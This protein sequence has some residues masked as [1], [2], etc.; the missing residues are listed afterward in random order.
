VCASRLRRFAKRSSAMPRQSRAAA[1]EDSMTPDYLIVGGGSAGC[2]LAERLSA[3]PSVRGML[4]E[5]GGSDRSPLIRA[6]GGLLPIMMSGAYAWRYMSAPQRHLDQRVLYT[7][8]GKV[9]G[10]GSSIN[11]MVYCRGTASDY[12]HWAA[13][14][15]RGW[16]Y[17]EVLPYFKRAENYYAGASVYHGNSGPI[18]VTRP[19]I[20]SPLAQAF[21]AAGQ[22]AG[23]AYND[24]TNAA[25]RDGFGPVDLTVGAGRRSSTASAY[26]RPALQRPNLKVITNAQVTR[27]LLEGRRAAG[28]EY[29]QGGK[30]RSVTAAREVILAAGAINSPQLL[31]LSGIGPAA[32]LQQHGIS[33]VA[34]L[35][36]VGENLQ[37]HLAVHVKCR[38]T[39]PL[40][41]LKYVS[42]VR[43]AIALGRYL[44]FRT[45]PLA[46]PGMEAIAFLRSQGHLA[47]PDLKIHFIMALYSNNGRSLAP[48]H[49]FSA[50]INM[51]HP[52]SIGRL[53][54][55][56]SD[57]LQPPVIDQNY[58]AAEQ[59]RVALR[60]GIQIAREVFGQ[61]AF[62]R[63]R[64]AE[65]AP[66]P[67]I[68]SDA[69]I[70]AYIRAKAEAD[71]HSVGTCRM[72][73][74]RDAV[75][76]DQLRVHGLEC[77]RVV[78]ASVMPRIV[79]GN[80]N[81]P[82]IM[83]AERAADLI[84]GRPALPPAK[85]PQR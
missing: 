61:R 75:V 6:P 56:G 18:Q 79:G 73:S 81:M 24:D 80:T 49:G 23:Y 31:L 5:A 55:A 41:M 30:V 63:Y 77:L 35:P 69:A 52:H 68:Q 16:S 62:D 9:L 32:Q 21:V 25:E 44:L 42:P 20:K 15:N 54:L 83:I 26:L 82:V 58:L 65:L 34:D 48:M 59:D 70:D 84:L 13:L 12:D 11:G 14:G 46:D 60:R 45:G 38:A 27:I 3:E 7:P 28:V 43:G 39:Q 66:G 78:D 67:D 64:G 19:K 57:P 51:T 29:L 22:Q 71:Y 85:L 10:G 36:G 40:S 50:H 33:V 1:F 17:A 76:D 4:L 37:D 74:D 8:R 47:E 53:T 72:G 2:V